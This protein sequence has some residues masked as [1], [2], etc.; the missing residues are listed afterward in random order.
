[1]IKKI[2][3]VALYV[4]DQEMAVD[5]WAKRVGFEVRT[6]RPLGALGSWIEIAPPG[7]ES[8]LVLYPKALLPDWAQRK[9][10]VVFDCDDVHATVARMKAHGVRFSQEPTTM[11]WGPFAAFLDSEGDEH[12]L[13]GR[14]A[15]AQ[16]QKPPT[17]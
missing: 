13:R 17:V 7:A 14:S 5:F 12:G 6:R 15:S 9:P 16:A 8:C 4:A 11:Q 2:A 1:M 10:S 3:T